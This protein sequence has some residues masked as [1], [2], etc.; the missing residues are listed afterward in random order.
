MVIT[1]KKEEE[2]PSERF[3]A[4]TFIDWYNTQNRTAYAIQRADLVFPELVGNTNWDYVARQDGSDGWFGIEVKNVLRE[5]LERRSSDWQK[6]CTQLKEKIQT[7]LRGTVL[8]HADA[9]IAF[10]QQKRKEL[11]HV[12]AEVIPHEASTLQMGGLKDIGPAVA[13]KFSVWPRERSTLDEYKQWG[14][15]R[16]S[17]LYLG[18]D[19]RQGCELKLGVSSPSNDNLVRTCQERLDKIFDPQKGPQANRQL[20]VAKA[21]GADSTVLLLDCWLVSELRLF[22]PYTHQRL[23]KLK[24]H[25]LSAIDHIYL[26]GGQTVDEVHSSSLVGRRP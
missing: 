1:R 12:L 6:L 13:A 14:E 9:T 3:C 4:Q 2:K 10:P 15:W 24:P 23:A 17:R 19:S 26:V 25:Q 21:K 8:I 16:P 18:L 22:L 7:E 5:A 20:A 11:L